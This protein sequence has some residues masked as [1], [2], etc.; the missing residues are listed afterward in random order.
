MNNCTAICRRTSRSRNSKQTY[1]QSALIDWICSSTGHEH[2]QLNLRK[3][4]ENLELKINLNNFKSSNKSMAKE[5]QKNEINKQKFSE[6]IS[7]VKKTFG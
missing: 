3:I 5:K 4:H 7:F 6:K 2:N 1:E